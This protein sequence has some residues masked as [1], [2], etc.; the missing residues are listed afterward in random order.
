[1]V[2]A[3]RQVVGEI[4]VLGL[5]AERLEVLLLRLRPAPL[6]RKLVAEREVEDMRGR[7]VGEHELDPAFSRH[8][9]DPSGTQRNQRGV[10]MRIA[11]VGLQQAYIRRLGGLEATGAHV[12]RRHAEQGVAVRRF[13]A[14]R[15]LISVRAIARSPATY[16]LYAE[17]TFGCTWGT[18]RVLAI[19]VA[20]GVAGRG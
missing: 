20:E 2:Q 19:S 17:P 13:L 1:M 6:L 7:I 14:Q 18:E 16:A 8:G 9:I 15:L 11:R 4:R 5:R 12:Q 10:R 3:H